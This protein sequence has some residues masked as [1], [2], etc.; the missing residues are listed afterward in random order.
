M[1]NIRIISSDCIKNNIVEDSMHRCF[2]MILC[3]SGMFGKRYLGTENLYLVWNLFYGTWLN[4]NPLWCHNM[5]LY[6]RP[7]AAV[8]AVFCSWLQTEAQ[9]SRNP[10]RSLVFPRCW[11]C[12]FTATHTAA[13]ASLAVARQIFY[14]P[15]ILHFP[16][17]IKNLLQFNEAILTGGV[18]CAGSR[19]L[20]QMA[21]LNDDAADCQ[22][23]G[24]LVMS[25]VTTPGVSP[26]YPGKCQ[27]STPHSLWW[28]IKYYEDPLLR[29]P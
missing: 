4:T 28:P 15:F 18:V 21:P 29:A 13:A 14:Q 20:W 12:F 19:R 27:R 11:S 23:G 9:D 2:I 6:K 16:R 10:G 3:T 26:N 7:W 1:C 22:V 5:H 17:G 8:R 24:T 25:H